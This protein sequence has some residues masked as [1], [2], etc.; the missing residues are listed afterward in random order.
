MAIQWDSITI[1]NPVIIKY[2][3][4]LTKHSCKKVLSELNIAFRLNIH[5]PGNIGL[6]EQVK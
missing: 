2:S 3:V 5:L 6:G 4:L 1:K